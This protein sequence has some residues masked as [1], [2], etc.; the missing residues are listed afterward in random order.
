MVSTT[1]RE[2]DAVLLMLAPIMGEILA[3]RKP[4]A[5]YRIH[6]TNTKALRSLDPAKL[7]NR[8]QQDAELAL[9]FKAASQRLDLPVADDP[10]SAA[11]TTCNI[12]SL[13][14]WSS[15]QPI[16]FPEIRW[17]AYVGALCSLQSP[18]RRCDCETEPYC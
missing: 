1:I 11:S 8:L 2:L 17:L 12:V 3:I 9:L 14:A 4:L 13:P 16:L 15:P 7:R 18:I 10:L 6:G 5:R